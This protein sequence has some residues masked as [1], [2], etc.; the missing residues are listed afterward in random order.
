MEIRMLNFHLFQ[1]MIIIDPLS[2]EHVHSGLI[3]LI[4]D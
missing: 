2:I 4:N 1:S 3:S